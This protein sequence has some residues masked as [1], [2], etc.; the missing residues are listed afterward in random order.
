MTKKKEIK[1]SV[2]EGMEFNKPYSMDGTGHSEYYYD[3]DRNLDPN[4]F[5]SRLDKEV[6]AISET[7]NVTNFQETLPKTSKAVQPQDQSR[8]QKNQKGFRETKQS[9]RT[10]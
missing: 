9:R 4:N 5:D 1:M 8:S 6:K 10:T 2:P 7:D 3:Y